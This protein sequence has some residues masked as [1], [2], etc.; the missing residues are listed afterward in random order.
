MEME[1]HALPSSDCIVL[2]LFLQAS[3]HMRTNIFINTQ[4]QAH[5]HTHMYHLS[6]RYGLIP[7]TLHF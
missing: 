1:W 2:A 7:F 6:P 4:L 5:I 3:S